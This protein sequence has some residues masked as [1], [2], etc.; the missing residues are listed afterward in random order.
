MSKSSPYFFISQSLNVL[1]VTNRFLK[2]NCLERV[3][4]DDFVQIMTVSGKDGYESVG[5]L[6]VTSLK[7]ENI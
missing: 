7:I 5:A 1:L 3:N 6:V 4:K 2:K